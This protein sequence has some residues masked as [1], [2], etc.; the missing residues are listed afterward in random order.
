M[1]L[2][3][4]SRSRGWMKAARRSTLTCKHRIGQ[5]VLR[6]YYQL[7]TGAR[8]NHA[9]LRTGSFDTLK[10]DDTN[11][12]Y[13]YGRKWISGTTAS[14]AAVVIVNRNTVTQ[15]ITVEVGGYL[16]NG[17][18]F[19]DVLNSGAI[20]TVTGGTI[21]VPDVPPMLGALLV[22]DSGDVIPPAAPTSLTATEG[23]AQVELNWDT[24]AGAVNYNVYRSL[25]SGGGYTRIVTGTTN[26]VYTDTNVTNGTWYYY[27]VTAIDANGNESALSNEA[28]AL[29]HVNIDWANLQWPYEITQTISITPTENIYGQV[30]IAG[31]TA[32]PGATPGLLAQVGFGFTATAPVSWTHWVNAAFNGQSNDNDEFKAQLLPEVVGEYHYVYRYSTTNGRDWFYADRS[33]P[34][35]ASSVVTPGLLHVIPSSD[36][37]PPATPLNLRVTHWGTDHI[38]L[39]WDPVADS[40]LYAYD[41][42]RYS[43]QQTP[44]DMAKIGRVLAP[45]AVYTDEA[46]IGGHTYTYT[47]KA[48]DTSFN[49][50]SASNEAVGQAIPRQ[51]E[52][53]F[54]ATVPDFT[55]TGD[56]VY[57]AGDNAAAFGASWNPGAQPIT[58]IN[59]TEWM[60]TVTIGEGTALL[61]KYTRGSWDVVEN[62]GSLVG[63]ANRQLTTAYG[64]DRHHDGDGYGP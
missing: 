10:V 15:T 30:Y 48:L 45:T 24:V 5:D 49:A 44:G 3:T 56:T 38:T 21:T 42:Y 37:T 17:T 18:V 57:I 36:T 1:I 63:V 20:Y 46:V 12:V 64:S 13:V 2:T 26:T 35:S 47:V 27:A 28:S 62:W 23:D 32:G 51:V 39:A 60:Y 34:I 11:K 43:D 31:V 58:K 52:L 41:L 61:Y 22:Y 50:S 33:G 54:F 9:A 7:L 8:N 40:D 4:A 53:R 19:S 6:N 14:D 25:L 29:P 59:A 55:P 16:G